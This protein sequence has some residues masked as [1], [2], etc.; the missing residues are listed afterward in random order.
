IVDIRARAGSGVAS[1]LPAGVEVVAASDDGSDIRA[2]LDINQVEA[3]AADADVIFIQ[4]RQ[5]ATLSQAVTNLVAP[6]RPGSRS[7]E[8]AVTH[9]AFAAR[10]AFHIDGAGLKIGVLS[11]GVRNLAASQASGDLGPVTVIGNPAPCPATNSCD[12]GTAML[13]IVHDLAPGAQLYFASAFVNITTFADNIR[14]LRAAGCSVIVDDVFYF[15]ETPFQDGQAPGVISTTNGGVVIQAVKDVT[16]SGALY[17]SS[18]G[19]SGNLDAG[20][21]GAWEGDFVDGGATGAP[22]P[23]G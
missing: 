22:L 19:N 11:D 8:G 4:P 23:A 21:A 3:L 18:A 5:A 7:S 14:A 13:E 9:Q 15:V 1:R 2:H 20:T 16:A 10:G 6:T 17:F 12:E